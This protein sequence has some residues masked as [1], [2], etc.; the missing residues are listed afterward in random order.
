MDDL[1][2]DYSKFC[3][4]VLSVSHLKAESP[5]RRLHVWGMGITLHLFF[6]TKTRFHEP[7][8]SNSIQC[9]YCS[10]LF[11]ITLLLWFLCWVVFFVTYPI[12]S[13]PT[14]TPLPLSPFPLFLFWFS[15]YAVG[16]S[17]DFF[18]LYY[19][20]YIVWS[21]TN[22]VRPLYIYVRPSAL[23]RVIILEESIRRVVFF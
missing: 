17:I 14:Q 15:T 20:I 9:Y 4:C 16:F 11:S 8:D 23:Y 12:Q 22:L 19:T 1:F 6:G 3:H 2:D 7:Y 21:I 18:Y 5:D 10:F 13:N